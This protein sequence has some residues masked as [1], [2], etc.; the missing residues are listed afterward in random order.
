[1]LG[2]LLR[3]TAIFVVPLAFLFGRFVKIGEDTISYS[4]RHEPSVIRGL[5]ED[6]VGG[7]R[8]REGWRL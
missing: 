8:P 7:L 3:K 2:V 6:E 1:M 4:A 5:A